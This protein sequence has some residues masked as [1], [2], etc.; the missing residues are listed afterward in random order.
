MFQ[1]LSDGDEISFNICF[2]HLAHFK[3]SFIS[4]S[5]NRLSA[6]HSSFVPLFIY[7][8]HYLFSFDYV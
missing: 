6:Y 4:S 7:I 3:K 5:L 1:G 8:D 2:H